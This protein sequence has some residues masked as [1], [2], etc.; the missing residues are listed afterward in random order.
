MKNDKTR[1][2]VTNYNSIKKILTDHNFTV[3][4][5]FRSSK[6]LFGDTLMDR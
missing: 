4:S 2:T 6:I 5:P 3:D 1:Y